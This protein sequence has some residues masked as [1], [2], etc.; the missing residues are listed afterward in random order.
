VTDVQH[1]SPEALAR[2]KDHLGSAAKKAIDQAAD[3]NPYADREG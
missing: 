2:L 1:W 3:D